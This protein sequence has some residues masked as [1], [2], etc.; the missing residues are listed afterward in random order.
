MGDTITPDKCSRVYLFHIGLPVYLFQ[1]ALQ[2][3]AGK[4]DK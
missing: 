3:C 2:S 4:A 1:T